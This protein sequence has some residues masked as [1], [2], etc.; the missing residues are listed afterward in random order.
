MICQVQRGDCPLIQQVLGQVHHYVSELGFGRKQY[1]LHLGSVNVADIF[2]FRRS[3][4]HAQ[5]VVVLG[6]Q[7]AQVS[8]VEVGVREV[9]CAQAEG[10]LEVQIVR[11]HAELQIQ[12]DNASFA[13]LAQIP[14]Q[15]G[16]D[17]GG[18]DA[19]SRTEDGDALSGGR[20]D[21]FGLVL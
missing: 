9:D 3:G 12:V 18:A 14:G 20:G 19:T 5:L 8:S 15:I 21:R 7:V 6:H 2:Q 17:S 10:R 13:V 16:G 11:H 4:Q 1:F